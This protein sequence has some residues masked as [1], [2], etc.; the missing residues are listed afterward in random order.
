MKV[1]AVGCPEVGETLISLEGVNFDTNSANLRP[2][3][4]DILNMAVLASCEI[5]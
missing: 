1:N 2:E 3:S 4:N 5:G